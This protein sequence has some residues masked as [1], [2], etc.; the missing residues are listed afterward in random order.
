[1]LTYVLDID[2]DP[3]IR[4]LLGEQFSPLERP[5]AVH[6]DGGPS[7]RVVQGSRQFRVLVGVDE[8]SVGVPHV[9][10]FLASPG[11]VPLGLDPTSLTE[12]HECPGVSATPRSDV[13]RNC[14]AKV[15]GASI[16]SGLTLAVNW[17]TDTLG[18]PPRVALP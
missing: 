6:Q 2:V 16:T 7:V 17:L 4:E 3:A 14:G 9:Y 11:G 18:K 12:R 13:H 5:G 15:D 8:V 1:M 10:H